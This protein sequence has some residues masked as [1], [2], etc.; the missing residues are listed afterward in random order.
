MLVYTDNSLVDP[1]LLAQLVLQHTKTLCPLVAVQPLYMHPYAVAKLVASLGFLHQR[2]IFLNM[3][4]GGFR[5][6]L[7]ALDDDTDHDARYD[8]LVEYTVIVKGLLA[9]PDAYSFE[10]SYYQVKNVKMT[11]ALTPELFPGLTVSGS[12]EAGLAAARSTGAT[13]VKYPQ[14]SSAE[15]GRLATDTIRLGMR[16]GVIARTTGEEAWTVAYTRFPES[17]RGQLTHKLAMR[18][19]DSKWHQQLS[20]LAAH[21]SRHESPYWLGPFENYK[22]FCPYLVGS[23]ETVAV[24][25]ARYLRLGF[26]TFILDIPWSP[27]DLVHA[28]VAFRR[29]AALAALEPAETVTPASLATSA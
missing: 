23:Y 13:A 12:S 16:A 7:L 10:G 3:V 28:D 6:D 18:V 5:N 26:R 20:E 29:A 19:S 8:R 15:N 2:R 17:R 11:P 24:E 22:T 21:A 25:L 4:A 27:E 9:G 14:P 1:W